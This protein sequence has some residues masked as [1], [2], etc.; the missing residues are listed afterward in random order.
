MKP[1]ALPSRRRLFALRPRRWQPRG[2]DLR[3]D[4]GV[5]AMHVE[6]AASGLYLEMTYSH[7]STTVIVMSMLFDDPERFG[8]WCDADSERFHY[9]LLFHSLKRDGSALFR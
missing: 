7:P 2:F 5:L 8:A 9:P 1:P 4:D 3:S 6:P